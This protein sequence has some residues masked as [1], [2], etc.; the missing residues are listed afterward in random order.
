[1]LT[2][3]LV[4]RSS[5]VFLYR[6]SRLRWL[7]LLNRQMA[8]FEWGIAARPVVRCELMELKCSLPRNPS[9]LSG[10]RSTTMDFSG[11]MS[12]SQRPRG[13][14]CERHKI[15]N[16]FVPNMVSVCI[17]QHGDWSELG[18]ASNAEQMKSE[19]TVLHPMGQT[20]WRKRCETDFGK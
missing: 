10:F 11:S 6:T 17:H 7:A 5:D 15:S 2:E 13:Y 4:L 9:L 12:A 18:V 14:E 8:R 19:K 16:L 20:S 1:M 3:W